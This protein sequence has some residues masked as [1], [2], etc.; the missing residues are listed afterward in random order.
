MD[1][2]NGLANVCW[3]SWFWYGVFGSVG[4]GGVGW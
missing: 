3:C 4:V 1:G 2:V